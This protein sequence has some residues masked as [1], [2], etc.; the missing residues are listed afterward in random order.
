[1]GHYTCFLT[2]T[3]DN[4]AGDG[5]VRAGNSPPP[6]SLGAHLVQALH[7]HFGFGCDRPDPC[8]V[9]CTLGGEGEGIGRQNIHF[10]DNLRSIHR[11]MADLWRAQACVRVVHV[12]GWQGP[13][14]PPVTRRSCSRGLSSSPPSERSEA[15]PSTTVQKLPAVFGNTTVFINKT[16]SFGWEWDLLLLLEQEEQ[17]WL[18]R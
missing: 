8:A 7:S 6:P 11:W 17:K 14:S 10:M 5:T 3:C 2:R 12:G 18:R 15:H 16:F 9:H 13:P 1:M 4:A